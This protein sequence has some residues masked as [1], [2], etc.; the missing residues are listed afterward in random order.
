[1]SVKLSETAKLNVNNETGSFEMMG[2]GSGLNTLLE[3][4]VHRRDGVHWKWR[5]T[6]CC[7]VLLHTFEIE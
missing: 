7:S 3:E 6:L 4:E 1:M 5:P 2:S